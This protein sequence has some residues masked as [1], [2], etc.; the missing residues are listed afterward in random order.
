MTNTRSCWKLRLG[1]DWQEKKKI[2]GTNIRGG[3]A[4][5]GRRPTLRT[6]RSQR[7]D[8]TIGLPRQIRKG[9]AYGAR[10]TLK[11]ALHLNSLES[12]VGGGGVGVGVGRDSHDPC[13]EAL[14][15]EAYLRPPA[16]P[17]VY[18]VLRTVRQNIY[19]AGEAA[20]TRE[21]PPL[22]LPFFS[23]PNGGVSECDIVPTLG[24]RPLAAPCFACF[25][26][27]PG[28]LP[29]QSQVRA[30]PGAETC[31]RNRRGGLRHPDLAV[32]KG[33]D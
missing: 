9:G 32:M 30:E 3:F 7:A 17:G 21:S 19:S 16:L 20:V 14:S 13:L 31:L 1:R 8:A 10:S 29:L 6:L 24:P 11:P 33:P 2:G 4:D 18:S 25:F 23:H 5:H 22:L 12:D 28:V 15:G 26:P 27:F